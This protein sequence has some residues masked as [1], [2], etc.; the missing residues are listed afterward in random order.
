MPR[1]SQVP[2]GHLNFSQ[3]GG[4]RDIQLYLTG[5]DPRLVE[6]TGRRVL[7]EMR[8]LPRGPRRADQG[9]FAAS[10]N[11]GASAPGYR[12][13]IGRQRAEHQP[14]DPHRDARR[15]AAEWRE[16][17]LERPADPHPR[18][19]D[20]KRAA[21]SDDAGES[22]GAHRLGRERAAQIRGGFEFRPRPFGRA[23]LQ[24]KPARVSRSRLE[25]RRRTR[26]RSEENI[27]AAHHEAFA[28]GRALGRDPERRVHERAV[29]EF[30]A[31]GRRRH[32]HGVRRAGAVV[33]ARVSSPS[34]FY[35]RCRCPWAAPYSR[36]CSPACHFRFRW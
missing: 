12:G 28:R 36:C 20:R 27:C 24:S 33:R 23:P 1:L 16:V 32:P 6:Q 35:R 19:S 18:Q 14:D 25:S 30:R 13:A 31:G 26:H 3:G 8:A 2:D 10:G 17:F 34:R 7:A 21:R 9:R 29:P 15:S 22:A 5:D 4:G 11:R